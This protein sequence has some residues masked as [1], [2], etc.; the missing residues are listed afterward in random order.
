M[1]NLNYIGYN[2]YSLD[3]DEC[4]IKTTDFIKCMSKP[5]D[6]SFKHLYVTKVYDGDTISGYLKLTDSLI[7]KVSI[8]LA[9]IDTPEKNE[10]NYDNAKQF[11]ENAVLDKCVSFSSPK[12]KTGFYNRIIGNINYEGKDLSRQLLDNNLAIKYVEDETRIKKRCCKRISNCSKK[13]PDY[14]LLPTVCN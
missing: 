2:L 12:E 10:P 14:F 3:L 4:Q 9:E 6:D 8:R 13:Y 7:Y 11:T 1:D 5:L